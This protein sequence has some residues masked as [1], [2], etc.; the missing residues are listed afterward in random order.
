[1]LPRE[2][3]TDARDCAR[4][5]AYCFSASLHCKSEWIFSVASFAGATKPFSNERRPY[6]LVD[7]K[8]SDAALH[9][10]R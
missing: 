9:S 1:M 7:V 3:H 2:E 4:Y 8:S 5:M 6:F 10:I